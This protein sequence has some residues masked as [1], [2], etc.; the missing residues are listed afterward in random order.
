MFGSVWKFLL[1]GGKR[2]LII[3]VA[4]G[5][6]SFSEEIQKKQHLSRTAEQIKADRYA[7]QMLAFDRVITNWRS[8]F[9]WGL[10]FRVQ[11]G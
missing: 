3:D 10:G 4:L 2:N 8:R 7:T 11:S 9:A 1:Q 5:S 6:G